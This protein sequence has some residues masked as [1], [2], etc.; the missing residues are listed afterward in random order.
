M[1]AAPILIASA[2]EASQELRGYRSRLPDWILSA[3]LPPLAWV[4]I[5]V[6]NFPDNNGQSLAETTAILGGAAAYALAGGLLW[7]AARRRL[8]R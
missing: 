2:V 7:G 1:V 8:R 4:R 3:G 6:P 5:I